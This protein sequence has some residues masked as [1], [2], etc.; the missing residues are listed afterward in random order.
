MFYAIKTNKS[1]RIKEDNLFLYKA[2]STSIF[3]FYYFILYI[4]IIFNYN[5]IPNHYYVILKLNKKY[6]YSFIS[7]KVNIIYK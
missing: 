6:K 4:T 7:F 2:L 5:K 1:I 3:L